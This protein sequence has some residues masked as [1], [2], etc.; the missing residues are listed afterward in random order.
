M[1]DNWLSSFAVALGFE[2]NTAQLNTAKKSLADY[3]AAVKA[4]EQR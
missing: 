2:V 3:E 1:A 4:A